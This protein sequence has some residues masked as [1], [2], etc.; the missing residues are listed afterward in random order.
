VGGSGTRRGA[1]GFASWF[2]SQRFSCSHCSPHFNELLISHCLFSLSTGPCSIFAI[3]SLL[4]VLTS[5]SLTYI[6]VA[7]CPVI[8]TAFP[9][10]FPFPSSARGAA[11]LPQARMLPRPGCSQRR[12]MLESHCKPEQEM[13]TAKPQAQVFVSEPQKSF[14]NSSSSF[15]V[16]SPV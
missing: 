8:A 13:Q 3:L 9:C 12:W 15:H 11:L 10:C 6:F 16:F 1:R 2:N 4:F 5:M 7:I 14:H